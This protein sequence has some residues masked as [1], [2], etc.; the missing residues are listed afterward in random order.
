[1]DQAATTAL[2]PSPAVVGRPGRTLVLT[3]LM[4][5]GTVNFVDRQVLSV[6]AEPIRADLH[7]NDTEFGLLTGL[8]FAL[9]YA[10]MGVPAAMLADPYTESRLVAVACLIWSLF[11]GSLRVRDHLLAARPRPIRRGRRRVR[12]HP[13]S[14]SILADYYP[15]EKRPAVIGLFSSMGRWACS[16]EPAWAA[17]PP[18]SSAGASPSSPWARSAR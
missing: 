7:L 15:P 3:V 16:W 2:S 4:I 1:M 8:S 6:L 9:F 17:G 5:V 18:G 10:A 13:P 14:L 12:G 11:T